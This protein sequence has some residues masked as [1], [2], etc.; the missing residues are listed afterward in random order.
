M[1]RTVGLIALVLAC[2]A[3]RATAQPAVRGPDDCARLRNLQ[4]PGTA[5]SELTAEW[6]PAGPAPAGLTAVS[7]PAYCLVRATLDRRIGDGGQIYGIGFAIA[8]PAAWNGRFLLQGGGGFNG[9]LP[10]PLGAAG[11]GDTPALARGFAVASTDGGH[12]SPNGNVL[13]TGFLGDQQATLDFAYRALE[14]VSALARATISQ[15]YTTPIGR[16]YYAGCS[17]GGREAM[18]AA[19]RYPLAFDGV[20][21]GAPAMRTNY[22]ALGADWV[23]V[24]LNQVASRD[25]NGQ[26]VTR[27]ALSSQQKQSVIEGIRHACDSTSIHV[28]STQRCSRA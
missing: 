9:V 2:L 27:E 21:A 28:G 4:M 23:N 20:I 17:T 3:V 16:S 7:L 26:P 24:Q 19:Q 6:I 8:L 1:H 12:R 13:D 22:A 14:R 15:H 25:G 10:L 11:A 18:V 5:L